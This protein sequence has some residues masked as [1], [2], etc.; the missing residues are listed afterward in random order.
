MINRAK[1]PIFLDRKVRL[2]LIEAVIAM[3]R[4]RLSNEFLNNRQVGLV[5]NPNS[6]SSAISM[7]F[8]GFA[9]YYREFIKGI[10]YVANVAK[11]KVKN[12][13]GKKITTSANF[14]SLRS[15]ICRQKK[16]CLC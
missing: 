6:K 3:F 13:D 16:G 4:M 1:V 12:S 9:N 2:E 8:L 5:P 11:K 14:A 15:S 10:P 7:I